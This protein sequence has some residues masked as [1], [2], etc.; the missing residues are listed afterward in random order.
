MVVRELP[1]CSS[2]LTT[3]LVRFKLDGGFVYLPARTDDHRHG[4]LDSQKRPKNYNA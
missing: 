3:M 2:L 4:P 1:Y